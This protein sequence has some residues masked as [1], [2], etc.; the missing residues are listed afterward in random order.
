MAQMCG[1][2]Q[3]AHQLFLSI[4]SGRTKLPGISDRSAPS[5]SGMIC[6]PKKPDTE[7][8]SNGEEATSSILVIG[9]D[10]KDDP[11]VK[12]DLE[13]KRKIPPA[14]YLATDILIAD[15]DAGAL[16]LPDGDEEGCRL[17]TNQALAMLHTLFPREY[18]GKF[19]LQVVAGR[20]HFLN[21]LPKK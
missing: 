15:S 10:G 9:D 18:V 16:T 11:S 12:E 8:G 4:A 6:S 20:F 5:S 14:E 3:K 2:G 17:V 21:H 7:G 13:R 19:L 1:G